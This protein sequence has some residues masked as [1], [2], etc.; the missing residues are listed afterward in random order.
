LAIYKSLLGL[1]QKLNHGDAAAKYQHQIDVLTFTPP[2][3]N[4]GAPQRRG[5]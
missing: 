5:I 4:K 1:A 3:P 2:Q